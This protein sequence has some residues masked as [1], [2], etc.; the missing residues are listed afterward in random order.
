MALLDE[1]KVAL[2]ASST[3][4]A[5]VAVNVGELAAG[6]G[7]VADEVK[8]LIALIGAS[9]GVPQ[10]VVDAAKALQAS[11]EALVS[12]TQAVEDQVAAIPPAPAAG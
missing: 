6:V 4:V 11:T 3:A 12:K 9:S 8:V 1:L 2:A 10:D 7:G 5:A